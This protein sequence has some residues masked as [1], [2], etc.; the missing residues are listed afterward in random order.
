MINKVSR[1][2][3][4]SIG[5]ALAFDFAGLSGF[6]GFATDLPVLAKQS[7]PSKT[8]VQVKTAAPVWKASDSLESRLDKVIDN[9][10]G[11]H[12]KIVGC[13]V[14]VAKDGQVVYRKAKG[15]ADREA[16][17][18]M[19]EDAIFRLASMSKPITSAVCL[20][21]V[22]KGKLRLD[23]AVSK[24]LPDFKPLGPDGQPAEITIKQ[25]LTHTSGLTYNFLEDDN[26]PYHQAKVSDGLDQPGLSLD[27]NLK[28]LVSCKL[29]FVPGAK[30]QY[31]LSTDVLGAVCQ[32][33]GEKSLP[34]LA[35]EYV[36]EPLEMKDTG[37]FVKLSERSRVA[38]PYADGK[39]G[40]APTAMGERAVLQFPNAG[41]ITFMPGRVFE[42]TSYASGGGGM[43]GTA[44]DYYRFLSCL[45]T[46]G[47]P[48][49][50]EATTKS[51]MTNQIEDLRVFGGPPW[52]GFG[53]GFAVRKDVP[54]AGTVTGVG[55][56]KWGGAYGHSF[57]L[58]PSN[59]LIIIICTN[60]A[61][62]GT[63]GAFPN[64][65]RDAVYGKTLAGDN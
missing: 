15:L 14:I 61:F 2:T 44:D 48:I 1:L 42:K 25:L 34:E 3:I 53:Y 52:W 39:D 37:Y 45:A 31:G 58:D 41:H 50:T 13:V 40:G 38:K 27:E 55:T 43:V 65:I 20:A 9:S 36:C 60:T 54:D 30:F 10:I 19:K 4:A 8:A 46:G 12:N 64:N 33:A 16:N 24:Y 47:K 22:D 6:A 62:E 49:L 56:C 26:G 28:R 29:L 63:M 57:Y 5:L 11:A 59:K 21:L 23:D 18:A 7:A 17:T 35:Q 51:M 32:A